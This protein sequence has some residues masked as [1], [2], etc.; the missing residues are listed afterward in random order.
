MISLI[1]HFSQRCYN[2]LGVGFV[3]HHD[4]ALAFGFPVVPLHEKVLFL[5]HAHCLGDIWLDDHLSFEVDAPL[6]VPSEELVVIEG[7]KCHYCL[8]LRLI[9]DDLDVLD[10]HEIIKQVF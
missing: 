10:L 2:F 8:I 7:I 6:E 3:F 9:F 1:S 5:K 4:L